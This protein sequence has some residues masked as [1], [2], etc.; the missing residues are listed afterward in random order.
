MKNLLLACLFGT[1]LAAPAYAQSTSLQ[2]TEARGPYIGLG[3]ATSR[4]VW[5]EGTDASLKLF[6]GYDFN[7]TWGVEAGF[8]GNSRF[9]SSLMIPEGSTYRAVPIAFRTRTGYLAAKATMP[10]SER[11]SIVTKL[12]VAA[13][14]SKVDM[15]DPINVYNEHSSSTKY[16][17]YAGIGLKYQLTEKV[18]LSLE[19]ER[20]GRTSYQ[21]TKPETVSLNA[22][23]RF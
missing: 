3:V 12:G 14:R 6:G 8:V 20:M 19:L 7:R 13:S 23:Y 10:V 18:S 21:G 9:G 22:S 2:D 5:V 16:G 15:S 4:H 1:A 11:F 17:L